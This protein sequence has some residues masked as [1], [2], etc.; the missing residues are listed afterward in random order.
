MNPLL[1]KAQDWLQNVAAPQAEQLDYDPAALREAILQMFQNGFMSMKRPQ[2]YGGPALSDREYR[3]YQ[4]MVARH[5]GAIAFTT[6]QHQSSVSFVAG[7]TNEPL[8]EKFLTR[9]GTVEGGAGVA[10]SQLRK[11]GAP[12][13]LAKKVEGGFEVSGRLPWITGY[14]IYPSFVLAAETEDGS[15]LFLLLPFYSGKGVLIG[16]PMALA[17]ATSSETVAAELQEVFVPDEMVIGMKAPGWIHQN[18]MANAANQGFLA[19]GCAWAAHDQLERAYNAK[20]SDSLQAALTSAKAQLQCAETELF[21]T[22]DETQP[23][24][25]KEKVEARSTCIKL[26]Q[27]LAGMAIASWGG[28]ALSLNHPAQRVYREALLYTVVG[29]TQEIRAG[30]LDAISAGLTSAAP[31]D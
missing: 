22:A 31:A 15:T 27:Q 1:E 29:Q 24:T 10:F 21:A 9:M 28:S 13:V 6:T 5:S 20:P 30:T 16:E 7:G 3:L 11:S 23:H 8:K 14:G 26:A 19:L 2:A 17:V 18:D 12:A 25:L 4:M